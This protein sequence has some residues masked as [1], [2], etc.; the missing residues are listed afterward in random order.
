M[1][2]VVLIA[3]ITLNA[4][5]VA[6]AQTPE[7]KS[8]ALVT[9]QTSL[10][11]FYCGD[12]GWTMGHDLYDNLKTSGKAVYMAVYDLDQ[13]AYGASDNFTNPTGA[14]IEHSTLYSDKPG[15]PTFKVNG[16][17]QG[18]GQYPTWY[19]NKAAAL[20][21]VDQFG[22]TDAVASCA[23]N[24]SISGNKITAT[25]KAKFWAAGNGEYYMTAYALEDGVMNVQNGQT[26]SVEHNAILRGSM[27]SGN[28][29]GE[30]LATGAVAANTE[31][32]KSYSIDVVSPWNKNKMRVVAVIWK[33]TGSKYEVVNATIGKT[34]GTS[35]KDLSNVEN[36][37]LSPNPAADHVVVSFSALKAT[38]LDIHITDAVGRVVYSAA[39]T[40]INQGENN[41][42]IPTTNLANGVYNVTLSAG[43]GK[44]SRLLSVVK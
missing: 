30:Q 27:T 38:S 29:W 21:A 16:L 11:C 42:T 3:L 25:A 7:K 1:K 31:F 34:G 14:A 19:G 15:N 44:T 22:T 33:K 2:R 35:I 32:S 13:G 24:Y 23:V 37:V 18:V 8:V 28:V 5:G 39:A 36:L 43:D 17:G 4:A 26:G 20:T 41:I 10:G 12:W 9:K 40:K 6:M